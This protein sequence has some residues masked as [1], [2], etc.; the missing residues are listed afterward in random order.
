M[1][2]LTE[3]LLWIQLVAEGSPS[4][5]R[6]L[7][8]AITKARYNF[9]EGSAFQYNQRIESVESMERL[10]SVERKVQ[11]NRRRARKV[12][13]SSLKMGSDVR[14]WLNFV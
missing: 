8:V 11:Y 4:F 9:V 1:C 12:K 7:A 3:P 13:L 6:A 5:Q 2:G 10:A 14:M